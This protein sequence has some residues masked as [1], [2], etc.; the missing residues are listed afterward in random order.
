ME[1]QQGI[2]TAMLGFRPHMHHA[3]KAARFL[4]GGEPA[5]LE[6]MRRALWEHDGD[7]IAAALHLYGLPD[8]E[9]SRK[10]LEGHQDVEKLGK[11]DDAPPTPEHALAVV[12]ASVRAANAISRAFEN[13]TYQPVQLGGKHSSGSM[14][15]SDPET[16]LT[17]LL[18]PNAGGVSPAK[19]VG[20]EPANQA[21]REAA[22]WHASK[23]FGLQDYM[24]QA[25]VV[26]ISDSSGHSHEW[27]AILMLPPDWKPVEEYRE[28]DLNW[29]IRSLEKYRGDGTLHQW[30]ALDAILGNP[31]RH[32]G[33]AL[34]HNTDIKLIDQG[35]A[36]AGKDF[37]PGSDKN[38][39]V[40]FY[41]R[42][43]C[44]SSKFNKLATESK[45]RWMPSVSKDVDEMLR[46]WIHGIDPNVL[47]SVLRSYGIHPD[48]CVQRLK[49]LQS[50]DGSM[51]QWINR[52]WAAS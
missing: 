52:F 31:D 21:R 5:S 49:K 38:S 24:P 47:A 12:P 4:V 2:A 43:T 39:F 11:G 30:G 8:N 20:E 42:Y 14:L 40:P 22:F 27:A 18:K 25:D 50:V 3:F 41:L 45:L 1:A 16:G 23:L 17:F 6:Q 33:N 46:V 34:M 32:W 15:A 44:P 13:G 19:G 48:A 51:S 9:A 29:V 28:S 7:H 37:A 26:S 35:S 10:A 36:L